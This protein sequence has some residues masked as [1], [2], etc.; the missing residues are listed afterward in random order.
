M[1]TLKLKIIDN[2]VG[3]TF[4]EEYLKHLGVKSGDEVLIRKEADGRIVLS[5][6]NSDLAATMEAY[7]KVKELYHNTLKALS[8]Q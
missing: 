5:P 8:D 2:G 4:P 1:T 7:Q 6:Y 3:I